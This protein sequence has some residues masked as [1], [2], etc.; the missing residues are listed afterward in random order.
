MFVIL[1]LLFMC[2]ISLQYQYQEWSM[3]DEQSGFTWEIEFLSDSTGGN[4]PS[5]IDST[6]RWFANEQSCSWR[7]KTFR[8]FHTFFSWVQLMC[9]LRVYAVSRWHIHFVSHVL[10]SSLSS[11]MLFRWRGDKP[12]SC[13]AEGSAVKDELEGLS[14]IATLQY[15]R[16]ALHWILLVGCTWTISFLEYGS[17]LQRCHYL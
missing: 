16:S 15:M 13:D 14:S 8:K 4:L 7:W 9:W 3:S 6:R 12:I 1:S 5:F 17:S 11:L 2:Y 10:F